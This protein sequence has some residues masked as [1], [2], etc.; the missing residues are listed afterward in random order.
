MCRTPRSDRREKI[1]QKR[2]ER[3]AATRRATQERKDKNLPVL[4][5]R[6]PRQSLLLPL[7]G[8]NMHKINFTPTVLKPL[9]AKVRGLLPP[10]GRSCTE[11]ILRGLEANE[12]ALCCSLSCGT[13]AI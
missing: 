1:L 8:H 13:A 4:Y 9:L 2:S 3:E 10:T 11:L 7:P 5:V 12:Q 6:Y